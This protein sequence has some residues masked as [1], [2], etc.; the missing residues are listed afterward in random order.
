MY[1]VAS[2]EYLFIL[3]LGK[4]REMRAIVR[5][6]CGPETFGGSSGRMGGWESRAGRRFGTMGKL[7]H[8]ES[9]HLLTLNYHIGGLPTPT[10]PAL[11]THL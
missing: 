8:I 6:R 1:I 2:A 10:L 9:E 5:R 7:S 3:Y 4:G 11:D